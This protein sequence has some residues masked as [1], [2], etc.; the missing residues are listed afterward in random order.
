VFDPHRSHSFAF[1]LGR[2]IFFA[3]ETLLKGR[4]SCHIIFLELEG[5]LTPTKKQC[6]LVEGKM[7]KLRLHQV[8]TAFVQHRS[9]VI[10]SRQQKTEF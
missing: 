1:L 2:Y 4:L 8:N 5:E 9:E 3:T 6:L 7:I 10:G